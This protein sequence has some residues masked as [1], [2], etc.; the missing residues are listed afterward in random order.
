MHHN[1]TRVQPIIKLYCN[2]DHIGLFRLTPTAR[3]HQARAYRGWGATA[4]ALTT[5]LPPPFVTTY[6]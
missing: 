2:P 5:V 4:P 6:T 1:D 3:M